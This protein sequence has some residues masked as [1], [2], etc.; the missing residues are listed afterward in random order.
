VSGYDTTADNIRYAQALA[1]RLP[2]LH[3]VVDTSRNGLGPTPDAQWCNAPGRAL[4]QPPHPVADPLID[5]LL[6]IK[7]PGESDGDCGRHE[8]AAGTFWPGY[9]LGLVRRTPWAA[10]R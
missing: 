3:A 2:G 8:P 7:H 10:A 4:G 1:A 5:A 6:W 9:A